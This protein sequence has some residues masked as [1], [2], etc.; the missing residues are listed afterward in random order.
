MGSGSVQIVEYLIQPLLATPFLQLKVDSF[1][2][3]KCT[4]RSIFKV[5]NV[6]RDCHIIFNDSEPN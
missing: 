2:F 3:E 6:F 1:L 5:D 4:K